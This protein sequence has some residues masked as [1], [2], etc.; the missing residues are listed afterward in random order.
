MLIK[1]PAN[2]CIGS[3]CVSRRCAGA[4]IRTSTGLTWEAGA[5]VSGSAS[6]TTE[7]FSLITRSVITAG[8]DLLAARAVPNRAMLRGMSTRRRSYSSAIQLAEVRH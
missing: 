4:H 2:Y 3:V 1:N 6:A 7:G 5:S 8:S